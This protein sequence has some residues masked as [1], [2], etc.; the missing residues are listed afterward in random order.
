MALSDVSVDDAFFITYMAK[1]FLF[2]SQCVD[3]G[4]KLG[5]KIA[6]GE[7]KA[8]MSKVLDQ[9]YDTRISEFLL[10]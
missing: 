1:N 10:F 9:I 5:V 4:Q 8:W 7:L 6:S 2:I 3:E